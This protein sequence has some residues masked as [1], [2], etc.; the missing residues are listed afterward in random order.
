M[1]NRLFS[2]VSTLFGRP[3]GIPRPQDG[4]GT[5]PLPGPQSRN[6]I[7]PN[8]PY[9]P[10]FQLRDDPPPET[11]R[12][13]Q[14]EEYA[15][16]QVGLAA[17]YRS[18]PP[19]I[20]DLTRGLGDDLYARMGLDDQVFTSTRNV[21]RQVLADGLTI[22]P[23]IDDKDDPLYEQAKDFK[24]RVLSDGRKAFDGGLSIHTSLI[25]EMMY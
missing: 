10:P 22:R 4:T 6:P 3:W 11:D 14:V 17:Y 15:A 8:P 5:A 12:R 20:D 25:P 16:A 9:T 7:S 19:W 23:A 24:A 21:V 18:L 1:A 13:Q 2:A